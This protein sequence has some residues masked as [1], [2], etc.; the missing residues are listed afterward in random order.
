MQLVADALL[1]VSQSSLNNYTRQRRAH[2]QVAGLDDSDSEDGA[3]PIS[4]G[5]GRHVTQDHTHVS[6]AAAARQPPPGPHQRSTGPVDSQQWQA[7]LHRAPTADAQIRQTAQRKALQRDGTLHGHDRN[8][9]DYMHTQAEPLHGPFDHDRRGTGHAAGPS[10]HSSAVEHAGF[11]KSGNLTGDLTGL[12]AQMEDHEA[13]PSGS[14]LDE[15]APAVGKIKLKIRRPVSA[16]SE[17]YDE[18]W[19]AEH[20][21]QQPELQAPIQDLAEVQHCLYTKQLHQPMTCNKQP[22]DNPKSNP[23]NCL[24]AR[25]SPIESNGID[26]LAVHQS[27]FSLS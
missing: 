20:L 13:G 9:T 8:A 6:A 21:D 23:A 12:N 4:H 22:A 5:P 26:S 7:G 14:A 25:C 19:F 24:Q 17:A 27:M 1:R 16:A 10:R 15:S 11:A 18:S 3:I 2:P